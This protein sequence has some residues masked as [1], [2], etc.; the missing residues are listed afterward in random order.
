MRNISINRS[1]SY[2]SPTSEKP[3]GLG[4]IN[5]QE[6]SLFPPATKPHQSSEKD[7]REPSK[8]RLQNSPPI[9]DEERDYSPSVRAQKDKRA[10]DMPPMD[11]DTRP[12]SH[13]HPKAQKPLETASTP[14]LS[15]P[16][17]SDTGGKTSKLPGMTALPARETIPSSKT[18]KRHISPFQSTPTPSK[19]VDDQLAARI[20]SL[21]ENMPARIRLTSGPEPDAP[22]VKMPQ[23]LSGHDGKP[24]SPPPP[25]SSKREPATPLMTL[26]PAYSRT[27]KSNPPNDSDVKLYHLHSPGKGSP[28]KLHVRLVGEGGERVMVRVGGGWADLGEYLKEYAVHHGRR[29]IS[30]G[31][32]EIKGLPAEHSSSPSVTTLKAFASGSSTPTSRPQSPTSRQIASR[33][34]SAFGVRKLRRS[35]GSAAE[36][37]S[38]RT[39]ETIKNSYDNTPTSNESFRPTL[40]PIARMSFQNEDSP[41]GL[42]GPKTRRTDVSPNKQAWV[43]GIL[44]QAR[45]T[46]AEKKRSGGLRDFGVIGKVGQTTRVF[47][48]PKAEK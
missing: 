1:A 16:I 24:A 39:P 3:R 38:P 4:L 29:S 11:A 12:S 42:A 25:Y 19:S 41:L 22:E 35:L 33:P 37:P 27:P 17:P 32:F 8:P 20:I 21:L 44:D 2:S 46:S 23:G 15:T 18:S 28:I 26:A 36:L 34:G 47:F 30:D 6:Y 14:T 45:K 31:R 5:L 48:K 9:S 43:N 13:E 10:A 7:S 40:R